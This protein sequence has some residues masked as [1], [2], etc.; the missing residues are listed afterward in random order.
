VTSIA[1]GKAGEIVPAMD[2]TQTSSSTEPGNGTRGDP[3]ASTVPP[4]PAPII[5]SAQS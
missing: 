5:E 4:N 1:H 2:G 3:C